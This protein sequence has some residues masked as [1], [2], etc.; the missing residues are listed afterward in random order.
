MAKRKGTTP[1]PKQPPKHV[2]RL[3]TTALKARGWTDSLIKRFLTEPDATAVNPH[4][5]SGPPMRL[6]LL[7]RVQAVESSAEYQ[8]AS[9]KNA[10]LRSGARK[11]V[12]SKLDRMRQHLEAVEP[13]QLPTLT[14]VELQAE[15]I[16][17]YNDRQ[18]E[19]SWLRG[20]MGEFRPADD[21]SDPA[22]LARITVNFVRHQLSRYEAELDAVA[23]KTGAV[24]ARPKIR[25]LILKAIADAYPWLAD[26]CKR[27]DY[28]ER[29]RAGNHE[30]FGSA[31]G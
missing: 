5:K 31:V 22:F 29:P 26:E 28:L 11:A 16:D 18:A 9:A 10:G 1:K 21:S 25:S 3:T 7:T 19:R 15:A 6:Y 8:E 13:P 2:E 4:Y 14:D 27:Q 23:G 12:E 20:G 17:H 24:M 30:G